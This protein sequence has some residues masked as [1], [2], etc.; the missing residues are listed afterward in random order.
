MTYTTLNAENAR[1]GVAVTVARPSDENAAE[2]RNYSG[3]I[4]ALNVIDGVLRDV[5]V[6][7]R[8]IGVLRFYPEELDL[9]L[10]A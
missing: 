3:T 7:F 1:E 2:W 9:I 6:F 5:R 4:S 8:G 10:A